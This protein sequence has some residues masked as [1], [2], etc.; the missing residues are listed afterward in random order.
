MT[1]LEG[2]EGKILVT[3][4]ILTFGVG[5]TYE[6]AEADHDTNIISLMERAKE[7]NIKFN[8]KKFQFK[9][10]EIKFVGHILTTEGLKADPSKIAAIIDIKAPHDKA[11]LLRF[12][13]IVMY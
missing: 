13:G 7:K 8:I 3:D 6:K 5:D 9:K 11:S 10:Q 1:A 2:L 12:I 4:D